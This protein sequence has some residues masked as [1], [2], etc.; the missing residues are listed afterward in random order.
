MNKG[1]KVATYPD[2]ITEVANGYPINIKMDMLQEECGELIV[3][4]NKYRR[5]LFSEKEP[6]DN[7]IEEM[8][9]VKCMIMQI[10]KLL[11]CSSE[12]DVII[13]QKI[14]RQVRRLR[15]EQRAPEQFN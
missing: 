2:A 6:L 7:L 12:V 9:D 8:A 11:E 14:D 4:V 3:A 1:I 5:A 15:K 13:G 10:E